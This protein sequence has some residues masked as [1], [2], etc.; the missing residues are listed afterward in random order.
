MARAPSFVASRPGL[1]LYR[2]YGDP[3]REEDRGKGL[4]E[5]FRERMGA[6]GRLLERLWSIRRKAAECQLRRVVSTRFIAKAATM[7]AA[8]WP[9]EKI[10]GQLVCGWTQD[11]RSR[12]GVN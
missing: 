11:E 7:Q 6:S 2:G 12:V 4:V 1:Q 10:I 8:G 3:G 9:S 5:A